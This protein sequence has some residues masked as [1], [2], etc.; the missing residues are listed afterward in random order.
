[1]ALDTP[2][3]IRE[4]V[5]AVDSPWIRANFDP[6]NLLGGFSSMWNNG[7]TMRAR[8]GRHP[9]RAARKPRTSFG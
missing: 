5:D 9:A 6:V 4:V 8:C 1:M 7:A 2:E 3:H